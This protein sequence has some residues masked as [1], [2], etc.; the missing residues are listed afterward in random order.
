M[1]GA[2]GA[3]GGER[4]F[5]LRQEEGGKGMRRDRVYVLMYAFAVCVCRCIPGEPAAHLHK[6]I[7]CDPAGL[8]STITYSRIVPETFETLRHRALP[9]PALWTPDR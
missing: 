9:F 4:W 7:H 8:C 5:R 2:A 3:K 1:E 6:V